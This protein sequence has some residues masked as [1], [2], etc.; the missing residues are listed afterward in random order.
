MSNNHH[1]FS[2]QTP[3]EP[4][5]HS[6][7]EDGEGGEGWLLEVTD[8]KQYRY[9][10]R[11][12]FYR[13]CLPRIRPITYKMEDG[14]RAHQ[15]EAGREARRTLQLYDLPA[16]ERLPG[17]YLTDPVL[18]LHGRL[19]LAI[20]IPNQQQLQQVVPVEYKWSNRKPGPHFQLQVAAYAHLLESNF[21]VPVSYGLIYQPPTRQ[22]IRVSVTA[23]LKRQVIKT[24][25]EVRTIIQTSQMPPPPR[26]ATPCFSCEFR[27]FCND[28]V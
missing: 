26:K 5:V 1:T 24:V 28:V 14:I 3:L 22:V 27:R 16:G 23:A 9:C 12:V 17:L 15:E 4:N 11:V 7:F 18:G 19:D 25:K 6:D 21:G 2:N 13:Y 20:A 10:S 8:L